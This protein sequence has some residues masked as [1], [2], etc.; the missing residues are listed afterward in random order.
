[1]YS[2]RK[3]IFE[4]GGLGNKSSGYYPNYYIIEIGQN[5]EESPG[6]LRRLTVTQTIC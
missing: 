6:E 4:T 5:T 3:I 2:H 1:M